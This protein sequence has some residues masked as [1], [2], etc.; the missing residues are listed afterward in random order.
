MAIQVKTVKN[1]KRKHDR[2]IG[3]EWYIGSGVMADVSDFTS[4]YTQK[5]R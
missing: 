3:C 5:H 1:A 2:C 4:G